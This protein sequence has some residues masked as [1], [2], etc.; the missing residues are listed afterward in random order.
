MIGILALTI[1]MFPREN[2]VLKLLIYNK[3][4][5]QVIFIPLLFKRIYS[6]SRS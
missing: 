1:Q 6:A 2:R 3:I 5:K 4:K